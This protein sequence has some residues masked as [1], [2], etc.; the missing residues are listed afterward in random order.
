MFAT[1][2]GV[3]AS[4]ELLTYSHD[5][6]GDCARRDREELPRAA[7]LV[8]ARLGPRRARLRGLSWRSHRGTS[9]LRL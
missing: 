8:R 3:L 7:P 2:E 9:W 5:A 6:G 4:D 1:Y